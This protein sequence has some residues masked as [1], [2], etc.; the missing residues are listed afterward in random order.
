M[1]ENPI[2][3]ETVLDLCRSRR[4][5]VVLAVLDAERRPLTVNDLRR[6][7]LTSLHR[8]AVTDASDDVL[9]EIRLSLRHTHIPKL[10]SAGVIEY[11]PERTLVRPTDRFDRLQPQLSA[12]LDADPELEGRI[13]LRT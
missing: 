7:V 5:R 4:R 8:T 6:T 1:S 9:T 2:A 11:D 10:E 13:E 3:F 12:V